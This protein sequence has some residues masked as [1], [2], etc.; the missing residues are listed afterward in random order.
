MLTKISKSAIRGRDTEKKHVVLLT[1]PLKTEKS[2]APIKRSD[3]S[4]STGRVRRLFFCSAA[5]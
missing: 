3:R 2:M 5:I 1:K 4:R